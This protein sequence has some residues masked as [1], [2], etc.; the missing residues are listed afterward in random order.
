MASMIV[1]F[2]RISKDHHQRLEYLRTPDDD[3]I[4]KRELVMIKDEDGN[5]LPEDEKRYDKEEEFVRKL[6]LI[7]DA[8]LV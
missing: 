3:L 5:V 8:D 1:D 4:V 7:R 2:R 6:K